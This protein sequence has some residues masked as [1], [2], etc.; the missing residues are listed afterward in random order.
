[1]SKISVQTTFGGRSGRVWVTPSMEEF[2]AAVSGDIITYEAA[3]LSGPTGPDDG[4]VP[5]SYVPE[6]ENIAKT[7]LRRFSEKIIYL[8]IK[9]TASREELNRLQDLVEK[10]VFTQSKHELRFSEVLEEEYVEYGVYKKSHFDEAYTIM[11][12][13]LNKP[14][15]SFKDFAKFGRA[16]VNVNTSKHFLLHQTLEASYNPDFVEFKPYEGEKDLLEQYM[17][18]IMVCKN[19][20]DY[21]YEINVMASD[22]EKNKDLL[23]QYLKPLA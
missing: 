20:Q 3:V 17:R 4:T 8:S 1:M 6:D 11:K 22:L 2:A 10:L 18:M 21:K 14:F 7:H 9:F 13:F 16:K 15:M 23:I 5:T 19:K 12:K